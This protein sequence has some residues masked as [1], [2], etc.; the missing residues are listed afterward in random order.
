MS[1]WCRCPATRARWRAASAAPAA[2]ADTTRKGQYSGDAARL[3]R[4]Q[5]SRIGKQTQRWRKVGGGR[6]GLG[7]GS[8]RHVQGELRRVEVVGL[9]RVPPPA[10]RD[11]HGVARP[12]SQ[13]G[14]HPRPVVGVVQRDGAPVHGL[15]QRVG[16]R[17]ALSVEP[18]LVDA[19]AG[20]VHRR[21]RHADVGEVEL[22]PDCS[23]NEV[24]C[25]SGR[26]NTTSR[27]LQGVAGAAT[28]GWMRPLRSRWLRL[29]PSSGAPIHSAP[30]ASHPA[31]PWRP[32]VKL[33]EAEAEAPSDVHTQTLH[34]TGVVGGSG[35]PPYATAYDA[36]EATLPLSHPP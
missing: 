6:R 30:A 24:T 5:P 19:Q 18:Q 4:A 8:A 11:C 16:R 23:S 36:L 1:A 21:A 13:Q 17:H 32:V 9:Q 15:R 10:Q 20:G 25:E 34:R 3:S 12:G 29:L 31:S 7:L 27:G 26:H 22:G 35:G 2:C 14:G 28:A 33:E